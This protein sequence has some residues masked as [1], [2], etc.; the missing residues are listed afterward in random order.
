MALPILVN[1]WEFDPNVAVAAQGSVLATHRRLLRTIVNRILG[2]SSG[3]LFACAYSCNS[4]TAGTPGDGVN[5]WV[6]DTNLVSANA[7][8]AHSWI[9][10][11][12][13][14]GWQLLISLEQGSATLGGLSMWCSYAAGF[15]GG[16]TTT[17]PTATDEFQFVTTGSW[18][19][20]ADVA[21]VVHVHATDDGSQLFVCVCAAGNVTAVWDV[22][23]PTLQEGV[24][25]LWL[26][27]L[28]ARVGIALNAYSETTLISTS[29]WTSRRNATTLAIRSTTEYGGT[30]IVTQ[31]SAPDAIT[32]GWPLIG[33]GFFCTTVGNVSRAHGVWSDVMWSIDTTLQP[34]G[35]HLPEAPETP[36]YQWVKI[37]NVYRP[38]PPNVA[39]LLS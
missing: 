14:Q 26:T 5:R 1:G 35:S 27:P 16:S 33:L 15:T 18:G 30:G 7:G 9:V 31:Y 34:T 11:R 22:V 20:S 8:S 3:S 4:V 38:N 12:S 39:F 24:A 6:S 21:S 37:G 13:T 23:V 29:T 10:I 19:G 32:G 36:L 28:V 25:A 17:R 2:L